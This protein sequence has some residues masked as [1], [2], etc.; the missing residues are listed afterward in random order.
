MSRRTVDTIVGVLG[1][2]GF[3]VLMALSANPS[4]FAARM[5]IAAIAGLCLGVALIYFRKARSS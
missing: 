2:V 4:S 1:L 5:V 3:G